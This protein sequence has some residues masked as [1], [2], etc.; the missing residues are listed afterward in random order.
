MV[1][2]FQSGNVFSVTKHLGCSVSNCY[3]RH[4]GNGLCQA[5]YMRQRRGQR[6]EDLDATLETLF[7]RNVDKRTTR[8]C[9]PWKGPIRGKGYGYFGKGVEPLAHRFSY[10][11]VHGRVPEGK[12]VCHSCDNPPCVNPAHLFSGTAADNTAD[13]VGKRRML[14]TS[15]GAC[16]CPRCSF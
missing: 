13:A 6:L 14:H 15:S 16:I 7:W 11:L 8:E 1:K 2:R 12:F 9:W 5:H 10:M 3:R 4:Y